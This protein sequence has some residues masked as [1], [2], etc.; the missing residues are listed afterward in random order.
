MALRSSLVFF[1]RARSCLSSG[2]MVIG[3]ADIWR[4]RCTQWVVGEGMFWCLRV[5]KGEDAIILSLS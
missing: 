5:V 4:G 3:S 1:A 2:E